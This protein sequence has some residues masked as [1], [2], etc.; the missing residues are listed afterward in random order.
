MTTDRAHNCDD[1]SPRPTFEVVGAPDTPPH[2]VVERAG[3]AGV[4]VARVTAV[5]APGVFHVGARAPAAL[6]GPGGAGRALLARSEQGCGEG[7]RFW[8]PR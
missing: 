8:E 7:I 5:A 4:H 1:F 6:D 2:V 3:R